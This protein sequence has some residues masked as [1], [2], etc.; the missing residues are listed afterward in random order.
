MECLVVLGI[1]SR[2]KYENVHSC[3]HMLLTN[4]S[5]KTELWKRT[6][7]APVKRVQQ[8]KTLRHHEKSQEKK[9]KYKIICYH[10]GQLLPKWYKINPFNPM[11]RIY[12]SQQICCGA[13]R[14]YIYV[15][16]MISGS[17]VKIILPFRASHEKK[18][19]NIF[20]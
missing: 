1:L 6:V 7:N 5:N 3:W 9:S 14:T 17:R 4:Y 15:T 19:K 16:M 2:Q 11:G 8:Q 13:H 18:K 20:R 10:L 12:T